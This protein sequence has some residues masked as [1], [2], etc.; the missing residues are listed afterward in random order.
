M[1][2][3]T[4]APC[5]RAC[6]MQFEDVPSI[7]ALLQRVVD[8]AN[9]VWDQLAQ[10]AAQGLPADQE[11]KL[12]TEAQ[13]A[14]AHSEFITALASWNEWAA[15]LGGKHVQMPVEVLQPLRRG[16]PHCFTAVC[17]RLHY[18]LMPSLAMNCRACR[19]MGCARLRNLANLTCTSHRYTPHPLCR[20]G[21][22]GQ[23]ALE[24]AG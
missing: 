14:A 1:I 16:G 12:A 4:I 2:F 19:C 10:H 3:R 6:R 21:A 17:A 7:A 8:A 5:P 18:A 24:Q 23:P 13:I 15:A 20:A 9:D 22:G 11:A